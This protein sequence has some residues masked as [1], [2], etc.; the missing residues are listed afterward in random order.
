MYDIWWIH[1][2]WHPFWFIIALIICAVVARFALA[3]GLLLAALVLYNGTVWNPWFSWLPNL[4][5][6]AVLV[7]L[8]GLVWGL[9]S[10]SDMSRRLAVWGAAV[11]L[12]LGIVLMN[13][14]IFNASP[15]LDRKEPGIT[16]NLNRIQGN[17]NEEREMRI[18][19][20][21]DVRRDLDKMSD[22]IDKLEGRVYQLEHGSTGK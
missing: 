13:S 21:N 9:I 8:V 16:G 12:L 17:L 11:A 22:R 19:N 10:A 3:T 14:D 1:L 5:T 6:L 2:D 4:F 18:Q 7:A 15:P 20:D